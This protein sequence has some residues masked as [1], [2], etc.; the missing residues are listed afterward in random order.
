VQ[1]ARGQREG[2]IHVPLRDSRASEGKGREI[3]CATFRIAGD[4]AVIEAAM[5]LECAVENPV[6]RISPFRAGLLEAKRKHRAVAK[7]KK[8]SLLLEFEAQET[9]ER[10]RRTSIDREGSQD[11]AQATAGRPR[12]ILCEFQALR[13]LTRAVLSPRFAFARLRSEYVGRDTVGEPAQGKGHVDRSAARLE[14]MATTQQAEM[15]AQDQ[16]QVQPQVPVVATPPAKATPTQKPA[17]KKRKAADTTA[18][19]GGVKKT[20]QQ[21]MPKSGMQLALEEIAHNTVHTLKK[22]HV[23]NENTVRKALGTALKPVM[24]K[25]INQ[26][27]SIAAAAAGKAAQ[28]KGMGMKDIQLVVVKSAKQAAQQAKAQAC[29]CSVAESTSSHRAILSW[30]TAKSQIGLGRVLRRYPKRGRVD[31]AQLKLRDGAIDGDS[32]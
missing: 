14:T 18:A 23:H 12:A 32:K 9:E 15:P 29:T 21:E 22:K 20:K 27:A 28:A 25:E 2:G 11:Q 3:H 10:A 17:Q 1:L 13:T 19:K 31:D 6:V 4:A 24:A 16:V 8:T 5:R 26:A 30:W 7:A